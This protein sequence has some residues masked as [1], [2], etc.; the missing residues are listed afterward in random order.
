MYSALLEEWGAHVRAVPGCDQA[1]TEFENDPPDLVLTDLFLDDG[2]GVDLLTSF[3]AK[4]PGLATV[5]CSSSES[6]EMYLGK[7]SK[8]ADAF[9]RKPL[10]AKRL[11]SAL[12][13]AT[14][15]EKTAD[16]PIGSLPQ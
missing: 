2:N 16:T 4:K 11:E 8:L 14:M 10:S 15:L 12:Q 3:R 1:I 9:V 6:V 7:E 5:L 13:R